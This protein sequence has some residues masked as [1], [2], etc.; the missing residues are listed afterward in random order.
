MQEVLGDTPLDFF[1]MTSSISGVLGTPAQSNYAADNSFLDALARHRHLKH[2]KAI[3][4]AIPM[5][6]GVGIVAENFEIEE[7][8]K[9]KG[10]YGIGEESLL[11]LF[12]AAIAMQCHEKMADH[13]VGGMNPAKLQKA[14]DRSG[15]TDSFWVED[16]R[17]R[18]TLNAMKAGPSGNGAGGS[19]SILATAKEADSPAAAVQVISGHFVDKL[20]RMLLIDASEF[21]P[22]L[23]S[24]G[25][26]WLD[27]MIGAE[28][29][30]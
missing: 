21:E 9:R 23:R 6:L 10:M 29:R 25:S 22:D 14:L 19:K 27:S 26:Y 5:V 20:S 11:E 17:F 12:E 30:N 15:T 8:L 16:A 1:V 7:S 13:I 3:S 24:I 4:I 2:Q 18:T 28:L